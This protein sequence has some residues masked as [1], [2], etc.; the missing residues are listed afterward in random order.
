MAQT[1]TPEITSTQ[2]FLQ[3]EQE[4]YELVCRKKQVDLNLAQLE[5]QLYHFENTYLEDTALT[6]NVIKGF[7]GYLGLRSEKRRG[8]RDSDRLFSNSSVTYP[9]VSH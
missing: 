4:L 2:K 8:I 3:A 6:G 9:K 1:K 7:D 5:T